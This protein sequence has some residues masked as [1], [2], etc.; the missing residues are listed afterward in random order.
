MFD[1]STFK[2]SDVNEVIHAAKINL[3]RKQPFIYYILHY[4][5][6]RSFKDKPLRF[7]ADSNWNI[8]YNEQVL[9]DTLKSLGPKYTVRLAMY[10][11]AHESLHLLFDHITRSYYISKRIPPHLVSILY[12]AADCIVNSILF[13]NGLP[14]LKSVRIV[15][16]TPVE[17][18]AHVVPF[19]RGD[20]VVINLHGVTIVNAHEKS[21]EEIVDILVKN[22]DK[23]KPLL[24]N[25][26][27]DFKL[28]PNNLRDPQTIRNIVNTA[29]MQAK[30]YGVEPL[31]L[32]RQL[33]RLFSYDIDWTKLLE[34]YLIR[35]VPCT[36]S[37]NPPHHLSEITGAVRYRVQRDY[38]LDALVAIDTSYSINQMMFDAFVSAFMDILRKIPSYNVTFVSCDA[39]IHTIQEIR[40]MLPEK[41]ELRGDG[42][43]DF[44]PVF[45]LAQ[46]VKPNVV[47]YFTDGQGIYP[48]NSSIPTVWIVPEGYDPKPPFGKVIKIRI[49]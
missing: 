39:E 9:E 35:L 26:H 13:L 3:L 25:Y 7:Y 47:I 43:T 31:G 8:Y 37:C 49:P 27:P 40:N 38:Y 36:Y 33:E 4:C 41:L 17:E 23:I 10:G 32:E 14:P 28:D 48:P 46:K 42:G 2:I 19:N 22:Y 15:D 20:N 1:E 30:A 45:R 29:L 16:G 44:R 6:I 18:Q 24:E 5:K 12:L 11:L 34:E 21:L